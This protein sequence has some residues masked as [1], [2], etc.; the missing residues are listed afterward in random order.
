MELDALVD[1]GTE[2]AVRE[3]GAPMTAMWHRYYDKADA[4]LVSG[5]KRARVL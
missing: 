5:V 1:G 4:V 3:V 2:V